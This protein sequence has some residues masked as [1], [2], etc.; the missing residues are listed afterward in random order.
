[1]Y[2]YIKFRYIA[3]ADKKLNK[4]Y[5]GPAP[6]EMMAQ[7]VILSGLNIYVINI[8]NHMSRFN[9]MIK[10]YGFGFCS[11]IV[12]AVGPSGPNIEYLFQLETA[13][14]EIG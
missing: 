1:L 12:G 3:S 5:L 6:L 8:C 14:L 4:N 13:L 11:Q 7:Y 2:P 10:P 9:I